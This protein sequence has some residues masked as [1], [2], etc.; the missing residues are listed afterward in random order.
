MELALGVSVSDTAHREVVW[1]SYFQ[2]GRE[3]S[4]TKRRET[5]AAMEH[6]PSL[7]PQWLQNQTVL[8]CLLP[9][10]PSWLT[11]SSELVDTGKEAAGGA[12]KE[13]KTQGKAERHE[14]SDRAADSF[15]LK[16]YLSLEEFRRF[17][18]TQGC[19]SS[20]LW[21][22]SCC[23]AQWNKGESARG[24]RGEETHRGSNLSLDI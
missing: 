24:T 16:P 10:Q 1:K 15:P 7:G 8:F 20:G 5:R 19:G 18:Q 6:G 14:R 2:R 11:S 21:L 4:W 12:A 13:I 17:L 3:T 22:S 9:P 23:S